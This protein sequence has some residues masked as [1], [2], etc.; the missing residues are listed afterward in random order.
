MS[1]L[2]ITLTEDM[3]KLISN[4]HYGE[5]PELEDNS[6]KTVVYGID[7]NSL[8]GGTTFE[9]IAY[10]LGR[11]DEHIPGTEENPLGADFPKEF[12]D[13][14]WDMHVYIVDHIGEIE[15]LVH[16]FVNKGGL[17]PGTYKCKNYER[18][19]EKEN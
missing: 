19:W 17:T 2:K 18:I 5:V 4:I 12:K 15:E 6:K 16:W 10:I 3:L 1:I 7:F 8:Y 13:Y 9:D 11:Y 14:M